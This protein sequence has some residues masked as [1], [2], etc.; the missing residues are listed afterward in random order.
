MH[1][2][3]ELNQKLDF[4][5]I[6]NVL[7]SRFETYLIC[8]HPV[9]TKRQREQYPEIKYVLKYWG[10]ACVY[11]PVHERCRK[12]KLSHFQYRVVSAHNAFERKNK[13]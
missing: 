1:T 9:V 8:M 13:D 4:E 3:H 2:A 5:N 7:M 6:T 10:K 11:V 12:L